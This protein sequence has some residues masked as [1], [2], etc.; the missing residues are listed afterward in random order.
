M[1][2]AALA[3]IA[4]RRSR[5]YWLLSRLVL[6][7]P[8][9]AFLTELGAAL[10]GAPPD[11]G[12]PLGH[13]TIALSK[14]VNEA[15]AEPGAPEALDVERTRLLAGLTR[16]H[17]A[18]PPYE[19]VF[20][21]DKLPGEATIAV[22]A[23]YADA[24]FEA[25]VPEAGPA[26]HLGAELRFL[27]LLCHRELEAWRVG[28]RATA[29]AWVERERAFLDDHVLQWVPQ[30]CERLLALAEAPYHRAMFTLIARAC[31]IDRDDVEELAVHG[32]A[33]N[34]D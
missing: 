30:H 21:E 2:T 13:E 29:A 33:A 6:E 12:L 23:A 16:T 11:A 32:A 1:E 10:D 18:P 20:R 26:D 31:L 34:V 17:G 28:E 4:Q 22:S 3:D 19:S 14:A 15:H 27:A 8:S 24:G 7:A 25:P 5:T 9:P